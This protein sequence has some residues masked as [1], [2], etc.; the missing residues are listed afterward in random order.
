M[1][2]NR[3]A[4]AYQEY[5]ATMLA[6]LEFRLISLQARGLL[7]TIRMEC[8]INKS[9]PADPHL[10]AKILGLTEAEVCELL[11][12]VMPFFSVSDERIYCPELDDYKAHLIARRT[13]QSDGGKAGSAKTNSKKL[14]RK[15]INEMENPCHLASNST[16]SSTSNLSNRPESNW[17]DTRHVANKSLVKHSQIQISSVM[18]KLTDR[19]WA[20]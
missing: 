5:P 17:R 19:T 3:D 4:P 7:Y 20:E 2:Q 10:L 13:K 16:S 1:T 14:N 6:K 9:L 8:W 12:S 11:P 18:N 15:K